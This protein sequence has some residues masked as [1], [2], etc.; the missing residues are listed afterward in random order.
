MIALYKIITEAAKQQCRWHSVRTMI[1][2]RTAELDWNNLKTNKQAE[3]SA[4]NKEQHN[5]LEHPQTVGASVFNVDKY[6]NVKVAHRFFDLAPAHFA[7]PTNPFQHDSVENAKKSSNVTG[8]SV[9]KQ[10][11]SNPSVSFECKR[12][13]LGYAF[14]GRQWQFPLGAKFN[15]ELV[16]TFWSKSNTLYKINTK[17]CTSI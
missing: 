17:C 10:S 6:V 13:V 7:W 3:I 12:A 1:D 2:V 5:F 16:E 8:L 14:T 15:S 9:R 4:D 11:V